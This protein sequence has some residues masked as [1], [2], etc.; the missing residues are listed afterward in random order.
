MKVLRR[1]FVRR[2]IAA[3]HVAAAQT[4]A[5]MHPAAAHLE[6][7]L[8]AVG[9]AG[10]DVLNLIEVRALFRHFSSLMLH[11]RRADRARQDGA[12]PNRADRWQG[13]FP[14]TPRSLRRAARR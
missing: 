3:T 4:E 13:S 8:A 1:V 2:V 6:T 5:Q 10:S 9:R 7:L 11:V 12:E 14:A